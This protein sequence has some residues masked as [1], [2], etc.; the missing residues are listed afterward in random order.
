MGDTHGLVCSQKDFFAANLELVANLLQDM[1]NLVPLKDG[2][3][4]IAHPCQ[5]SVAELTQG[6]DVRREIE[7]P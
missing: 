1:T 3:L 2:K 4:L 5:P 7:R 6:E